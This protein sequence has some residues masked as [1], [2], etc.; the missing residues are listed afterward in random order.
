MWY[1]S[2]ENR[3]GFDKLSFNLF[4]DVLASEVYYTIE[5]FLKIFISVHNVYLIGLNI[6]ILEEKELNKNFKKA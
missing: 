6:E 1:F 2:L 4:D 5:R 3:T